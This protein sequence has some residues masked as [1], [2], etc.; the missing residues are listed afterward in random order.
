MLT[1]SDHFSQIIT[2]TTTILCHTCAAHKDAV[3]FIYPS[4][5]LYANSRIMYSCLIFL[6]FIHSTLFP[7][8][9]LSIAAL[10]CSYHCWPPVKPK[11]PPETPSPRLDVV[12]I[13]RPQCRW[14]FQHFHRVWMAT[15]T[16]IPPSLPPPTQLTPLLGAQ[17]WQGGLCEWEARKGPARL[18]LCSD[19]WLQDWRADLHEKRENRSPIQLACQGGLGDKLRSFQLALFPSELLFASLSSPHPSFLILASLMHH[20]P[21][22][23]IFIPLHFHFIPLHFHP[24]RFV[25]SS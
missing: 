23:F 22:L 25:S 15:P 17:L 24:F 3:L 7:C 4:K 8:P 6:R 9:R 1:T 13:M 18:L 10:L 20:A 5:K 19:G 16:V 21:H 14:P 12:L 11:K 2:P